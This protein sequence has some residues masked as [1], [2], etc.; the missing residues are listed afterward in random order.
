MALFTDRDKIEAANALVAAETVRAEIAEAAAGGSGSAPLAGA[1]FTGQVSNTANAQYHL[2]SF[3]GTDDAKMAAALAVIVAAGGGTITLGARPHTFAN[4]WSTSFSSGVVTSVKI[5]GQGAA[6]DFGEAA[7]PS[8]VTTVT[9]TYAG[10][11]AGCMDF[12][13]IGVIEICGILFQ[14]ANAG[15]PLYFSTNPS[16]KIHN[17]VLSGGATGTA[18]LTDAIVLGGTGTPSGAGDT[19]KYGGY[20]GLVYNNF[21]SG[22]RQCVLFQGGANS[23]QVYNN[24]VSNSCGSAVNFGAPFVFNGNT[25]HR[26]TGNAVYGNLIEGTYYQA[27]ISGHYAIQCTLGPNSMWDVAN[28]VEVV[29]DSTCSNNQIEDVTAA[30]GVNPVLYD[31]SNSSSTRS[32][33]RGST[34]RNAVSF[35]GDLIYRFGN[36]GPKAENANG[37]RVWLGPGGQTSSSLAPPSAVIVAQSGTAV[38]DG[39]TIAGSNIVTSATA[40]F[41]LSDVGV[42]MQDSTGTHIVGLIEWVFTPTSVGIAWVTVTAYSAGAVA[43]PSV[44]NAHLY[45]CTTAGTSGSS[46]PAWPTSGG[47]VTDGTVVWKDLGTAT[48]AAQMSANADATLT[49]QTLNFGRAAAAKIMTSFSNHHIHGSGTAPT[50]AVQAAAGTGATCTLSYGHDLNQLFTLTTGT[51]ATAGL[52]AEMTAA[53]SLADSSPAI[54]IAAGNAAAATLL[55]TGG[56]V[57]FLTNPSQIYMYFNG[58]PASSTAYAFFLTMIG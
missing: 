41:V 54:S 31:S 42:Q 15:V 58:T 28:F 47:T 39:A 45:Q 56:G 21:F 37:T 32:A 23:I 2:D 33:A 8:G 20:Q 22:I 44:A 24:T 17:N 35:N 53:F 12:Q 10:S 27:G 34:F 6:L 51:G 26:C 36:E 16:P 13:H 48:T 7:A 19:V 57:Y 14:S 1:T 3:T 55:S 18:C 43:R 11:G 49:G 25:T 29:L 5:Q 52:Q 46:E 30:A 50:W 4:Q 38:T 9:F 40:T